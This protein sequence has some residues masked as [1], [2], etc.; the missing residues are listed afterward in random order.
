MTAKL[1]RQS[2]IFL[3]M[4]AFQDCE[5]RFALNW[6]EHS[7]DRGVGRA[8]VILRALTRSFRERYSRR[9]WSCAQPFHCHHE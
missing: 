5:K 2:V 6:S 3:D 7:K 4:V 9:S 1:R 8:F